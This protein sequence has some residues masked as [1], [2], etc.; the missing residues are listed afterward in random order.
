M[1][2]KNHRL[3]KMTITGKKDLKTKIRSELRSLQKQTAR[4]LSFFQMPD[5][6]YILEPALC[7]LAFARINTHFCKF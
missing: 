4:I 5:T 6:K 7:R 2:I 3:G 1:K